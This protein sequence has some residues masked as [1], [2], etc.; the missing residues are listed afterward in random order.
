MRDQSAYLIYALRALLKP[1]AL[2][3]WLSLFYLL[4]ALRGPDLLSVHW[5][6]A[7]VMVL[8][9]VALWL[10]RSWSCV[11]S[12]VLSASIFYYL[13]FGYPFESVEHWW[14]YI[15]ALRPCDVGFLALA[16]TVFC[17]AV[18]CCLLMFSRKRP[19]LS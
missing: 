11:L 17:F 12:A 9:V 8:A 13:A 14:T 1:Q 3:F 5:R 7:A 18:V 15:R 2:L 16:G 4:S 6:D 10:N 19:A